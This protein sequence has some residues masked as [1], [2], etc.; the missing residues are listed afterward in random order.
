MV[1]KKLSP[2]DIVNAINSGN[3]E[4]FENQDDIKSYVPYQINKSFSYF[5][6]T[7]LYANE[8]NRFHGLDND[9]QFSYYINS[10]R[11]RKRFSKWV[12]KSEDSALK[13][14]MEY[15]S[16]NIEKAEQALLILSPEQIDLIKEKLDKGGV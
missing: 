10:L 8:M 16:Y 12:K 13:S 3:R 6:D 11:P 9:L 7:I 14:V 2:F 5:P 4:I 1:E 15:Y